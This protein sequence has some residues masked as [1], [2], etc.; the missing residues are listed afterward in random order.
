M[1]GYAARATAA[2]VA[3]AAGVSLAALPAP[4]PDVRANSHY[5][6]SE[7]LMSAVPAFA[8]GLTCYVLVAVGWRGPRRDLAFNVLFFAV[9]S[10]SLAFCLRTLATRFTFGGPESMY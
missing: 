10:V 6:W 1:R 9:G 2:L 8:G 7:D 4:F 5:G 3:F